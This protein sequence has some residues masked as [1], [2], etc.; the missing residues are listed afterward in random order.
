M[1][2]RAFLRLSLLP[3]LLLAIGFLA[4]GDGFTQS[5]IAP[6]D[7]GNHIAEIQGPR[8]GTGNEAQRAKLDDVAGY[9]HDQLAGDGL[10]VSEGPVTYSGYTFPN[11]VGTLRGTR[12]PETTFIVG[13][14]YDSVAAGP[15]ADDNASGVAGMLE[16]A[17][18][19]S[20]RSFDASIDFVAF[21]FEENGLI[22]SSRMAGDARDADRELAG[23]LVLE[24]IGYTCDEPGCQRYPEGVPPPRP[25]GDFILVVG[26]TAS[27]PLLNRFSVAA[28]SAVPSLPLIPL[29][30]AGNGEALPDVRR[31]DHAPFWDTGYQALMISDTANFRNP[32]YHKA[33]DS[34]DTLDLAFA[35]DV[36]NA[37][38]A[39]IEQRLTAD[40]DGNGLADVCGSNAIGGT[41][42]SPRTE[43][44]DS[45]DAN[46]WLLSAVLV[47]AV[48]MAAAVGGASLL[49]IRRRARS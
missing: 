39:T 13:A 9:I 33:S 37:V 26:N 35:A 21:P 5:L 49:A 38:A 22:G 41:V 6:D 46:G 36:A 1:S 30:V 18:L 14:H 24:M 47:G 17:R 3:S 25:A 23:V 7:I 45:D 32:N 20:G 43:S 42:E 44:S 4:K 27:A 48:A 15:G 12:C 11:I 31:S 16:I 8:L 2:V 40:E 34:L 19:L 28:A 29:E 10:T